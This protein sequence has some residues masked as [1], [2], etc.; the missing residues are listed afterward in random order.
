MRGGLF[1]YLRQYFIFGALIWL[2][3]ILSIVTS[4]LRAITIPTT[5]S[6]TSIDNI[7][8]L[9][10]VAVSPEGQLGLGLKLIN[11]FIDRASS[12]GVRVILSSTD[13]W[14]RSAKRTFERVGF[15]FLE[16]QNEYKRTIDIFIYKCSDK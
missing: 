10:S 6:S 3:N 7:A 9:T 16:R 4:Y 5:S 15:K 2:W 12:L 11:E 13:D 1:Y 14:N 8:S